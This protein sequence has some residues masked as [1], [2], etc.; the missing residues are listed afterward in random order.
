[1]REIK[2]SCICTNRPVWFCTQLIKTRVAWNIHNTLDCWSSR[3]ISPSK[4]SFQATPVIIYL[5]SRVTDGK[6]HMWCRSICFFPVFLNC[7]ITGCFELHGN[8]M[9]SKQFAFPCMTFCVCAVKLQMLWISW[10][11]DAFFTIAFPCMTF[12]IYCELICSAGR[13]C[14]LLSQSAS[15]PFLFSKEEKRVNV[16][17]IEFFTK[18]VARIFQRWKTSSSSTWKGVLNLLQS[19]GVLW[20]HEAWKGE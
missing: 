8:V 11:C 14:A 6:Y 13:A 1:M 12:R 20:K 9:H 4:S 15:Y 10:K 16:R 18:L 7:K 2:D 17:A 3:D 5:T 19:T